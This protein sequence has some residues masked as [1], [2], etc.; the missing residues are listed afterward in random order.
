[1]FTSNER[2]EG[3]MVDAQPERERDQLPLQDSVTRAIEKQ[4]EG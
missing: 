2:V 3:G 1:M 4:E